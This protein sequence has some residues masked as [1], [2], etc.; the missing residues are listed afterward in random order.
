VHEALGS[1]SY[2][3]KRKGK[4]GRGEERREGKGRKGEGR[5]EGGKEKKWKTLNV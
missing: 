5:G 2:T 3:K 1:I 4:E